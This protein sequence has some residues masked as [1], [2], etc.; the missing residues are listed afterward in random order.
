MI[1]EK[2]EGERG[3]QLSC[4]HGEEMKRKTVRVA[5]FLAA[6]YYG[7]NAQNQ[8]EGATVE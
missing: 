1:K 5:F 8:A 4:P 2:Q 3:R 7:M 6:F